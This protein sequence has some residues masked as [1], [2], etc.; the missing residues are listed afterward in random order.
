MFFHMHAETVRYEEGEFIEGTL[1]EDKIIRYNLSLP[2]IGITIQVCVKYGQMVLYG[3]GIYHDPNS[4]LNDFY[5][6]FND[7]HCKDCIDCQE[8]FIN[9]RQPGNNW[10]KRSNEP[11]ITTTV[12]MTF[13]GRADMSHFIMNSTEGDVTS[14]DDR[15][16]K[17]PER[18]T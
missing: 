7:T 6:E 17:Y 3:S 2:S 4:A 18:K 8:L 10:L 9:T 12:Y 15:N 11:A 16:N 13:E 5:L 1:S 14:H